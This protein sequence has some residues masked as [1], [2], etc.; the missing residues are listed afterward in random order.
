V[1]GVLASTERGIPIREPS[2]RTTTP[3]PTGIAP[4][5]RNRAI[6]RRSQ[7]DGVRG[8]AIREGYDTPEVER[9]PGTALPSRS[10]NHQRGLPTSAALSLPLAT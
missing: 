3:R 1:N 7:R 5:A 10:A 6:I 8:Q 4:T 2:G 9:S